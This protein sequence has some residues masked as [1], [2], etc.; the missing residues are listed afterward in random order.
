MGFP[1]EGFLRKSTGRGF[2]G[3]AIVTIKVGEMRGFGRG[4][5]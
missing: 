3:D 1:V 5:H 2:D 4:A